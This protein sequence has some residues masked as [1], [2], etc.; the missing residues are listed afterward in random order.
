MY[1]TYILRLCDGA[2][3]VGSTNDIEKRFLKHNSGKVKST[4]GKLPATLIHQ[5]SYQDRSAAQTREYQIK[6]W[7]SRAAIERIIK[8]T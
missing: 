5:E 7:K 3:Y 2:Y 8:N 6:K 4:K 1:F